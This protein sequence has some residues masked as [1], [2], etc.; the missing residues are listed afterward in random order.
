MEQQAAEELQSVPSCADLLREQ[1]LSYLLG[2]LWECLE[3]SEVCVCCQ[4]K[5]EGEDEEEEEAD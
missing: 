1:S 2:M 3:V 4:E 5:S